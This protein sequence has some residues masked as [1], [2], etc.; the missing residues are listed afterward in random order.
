MTKKQ[1]VATCMR[2][3]PT[4][5]EWRDTVERIVNYFDGYAGFDYQNWE[6]G[7]FVEARAIAAAIY[8]R[9]AAY[10]LN[11]HSSPVVRRKL[12]KINRLVRHI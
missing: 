1:L 6:D 10:N 8:E 11:G 3:R 7:K 4:A 2:L 5:R 9:M 12:K